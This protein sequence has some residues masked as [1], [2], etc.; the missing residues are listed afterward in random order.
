MIAHR[1]KRLIR[2]QIIKISVFT[3]AAFPAVLSFAVIMNISV[4]TYVDFKHLLSKQ[5]AAIY[6]PLLNNK[7]LTKKET[8]QS[9]QHGSGLLGFDERFSWISWDSEAIKFLAVITGDL[10]FLQLHPNSRKEALVY[11]CLM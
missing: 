1:C 7:I 3:A 6:C 10:H 11:F 9:S 4:C 5:P 2:D 8:W